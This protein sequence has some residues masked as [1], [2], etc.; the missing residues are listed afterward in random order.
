MGRSEQNILG[1]KGKRQELLGRQILI[2][3]RCHYW[4]L[5]LR[6]IP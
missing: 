2:S 4:S 6:R 3:V 1:S 5:K